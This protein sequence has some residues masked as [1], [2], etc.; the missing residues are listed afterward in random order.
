M[1][2]AWPFGEDS[3]QDDLLTPLRIAVASPYAQWNYIVT[4]DQ[5]SPVRPT[6][7]EALMLASFLEEYK[8]YFYGERWLR[9]MAERPLDVDG[10]ANGVT[11]HKYADGDWGY[12][13]RSWDRGPMFVP[14]PPFI[15]DRMLGPLTL[16]ELLD[17]IHQ[18]GGVVSDRWTKWKSEHA[19]I[20]GGHQ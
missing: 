2:K 19:D 6:E 3:V 5:E 16:V 13:R 15:H 9:K 8:A 11:F 4:F 14:Q 10:S 12:R 20:F 7:Q 1:S 17:Y 18:V